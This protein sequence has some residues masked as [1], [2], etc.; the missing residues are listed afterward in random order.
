MYGLFVDKIE[1][2]AIHRQ[3]NSAGNILLER[4][5]QLISRQE[6]KAMMLA[7]STLSHA[8]TEMQKPASGSRR[9]DLHIFVPSLFSKASLGKY[10]CC[11]LGTKFSHTGVCTLLHHCRIWHVTQH[12]WRTCNNE[13]AQWS[14]QPC[15][16]TTGNGRAIFNQIT[17]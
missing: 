7:L 9:L 3:R 15:T 12:L 13:E 1:I 10:Y 4:T 8:V 17:G 14:G 11:P 6:P 16:P 5:Q 2:V